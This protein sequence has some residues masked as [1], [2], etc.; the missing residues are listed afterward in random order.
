MRLA[1]PNALVGA[2]MGKMILKQYNVAV[3]YGCDLRE[4]TIRLTVNSVKAQHHKALHSIV[5]CQVQEA[6]LIEITQPR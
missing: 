1:K 4:A 3:Q 6:Q 5:L 2:A